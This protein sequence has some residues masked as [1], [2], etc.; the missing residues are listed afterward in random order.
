MKQKHSPLSSGL[1]G[2]DTC[3]LWVNAAGTLL[4]CLD[5][6]PRVQYLSGFSSV[7]FLPS[8]GGVAM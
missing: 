5:N 7:P 3:A 2:S 6:L 8:Q 4:L 1:Q